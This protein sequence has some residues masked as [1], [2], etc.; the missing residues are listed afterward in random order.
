MADSNRL[1]RLLPIAI[2]VLI[3]ALAG[4]FLTHATRGLHVADVLQALHQIALG[5]VAIG[6]ALVMLLYAVLAT[7]E[8]IIARYIDGPVSRRRAALGALL[9]APIGHALGL[10]AVSG[11]A[12]RYRLYSAVGMRPLDIGKMVLL[13]SIPYPAGL[14]LLLSVSLLV[15]S[16]AAASILHTTPELARGV[17]LALFLLHIAYVTLVLKRREPLAFGRYL[18]PVPPPSLTGVQ[19]CVGI[20]EVCSAASILYVLLPS[21]A[22]LPFTVFIGIYVVSILAGLAS[23]M[24]AGVGVFDATLIGLLPHAP[25]AELWA[26]VLVYRLLLEL[27][28]LLIAALLFAGYEIWW[29]LPAQRARV[30]ARSAAVADED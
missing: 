24:P 8:T 23:S 2:S 25:Q 9:A 6:A 28:P 5:E 13:A 10:G 3:I 11:G 16:Q 18:L 20:I 4:R 12:I 14:G 19:Y 27:V 22:E 7:Y 30:A 1:Q 15:Q 17:G 26:A 29:R 21:S